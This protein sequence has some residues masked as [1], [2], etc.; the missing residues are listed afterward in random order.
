MLVD[1]MLYHP[2]VA[3]CF[4]EGN[5][6]VFFDAEHGSHGQCVPDGVAVCHGVAHRVAMRPDQGASSRRGRGRTPRWGWTGRPYRFDSDKRFT[7]TAVFRSSPRPLP[8][9]SIPPAQSTIFSE[10]DRTLSDYNIQKESAL[11]LVCHLYG[12]MQI[13]VKTRTV[14]LEAESSDSI[15]NSLDMSNGVAKFQDK[16]GFPPDQQRLIFSLIVLSCFVCMMVY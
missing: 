14:T 3:L 7:C 4:K 11:H 2:A 9:T 12:G 13:F 5:V 6:R 1:T 16:E 8:S 15:N 10:D